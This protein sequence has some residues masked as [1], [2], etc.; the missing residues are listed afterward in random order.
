MA[1][2]TDFGSSIESKDQE[3][4]GR[5]LTRDNSFMAGISDFYS[6]F[7][8]R[9][10]ALNLP[11]PGTVDNV[12]REVQKDVFLTNSM[13]TGLR[14]DITK[15]L[16]MSPIFQVSHAFAMGSQALPPYT[17]AVLYGTP[18]I[19]LQGNI[20]N[21][22][23]LSARSNLRWTDSLVTKT[24]TQIAGPGQ[25][26]IQVD[27]EYT[28][29]DFSA[30]LKTL[31]P[32]MLEGGLTGTFIGSYMQSVTP[33]LAL[34]LE[35]LWQ[36]TALSQ[37]PDTAVSYAARYKGNDWIAS[38]ALQAQGAIVTSYWRRLTDKVEAGA[39]LNLQFAP[40][41]G[42]A[43]GLMG[44]GSRKE[45]VANL[46]VKYDFR[47]STFRAQLDSTGRISCLLDKRVAPMIQLSVAAELDHSKQQGKVGLAVSVEAASEE[48][49][50][51]QEKL[52]GLNLPPPPY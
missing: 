48:T 19:F 1:S 32:S 40:G 50:E 34:G 3:I 33:R 12:A 36:R 52:V 42:G 38:A 5:G 11:Y 14:A 41:L 13:F 4:Y 49:M 22:L 35:T 25:A 16:S 29:D 26:M 46:G 31:N 2:Q 17:F 37:G 15:M 45:G 7:A 10:R 43:G 20:D 23:Q 39:D 6:A 28:G 18:R 47:A 24:N 44:P 27:N 51:Q 8:E 21:D 9:R 30:S